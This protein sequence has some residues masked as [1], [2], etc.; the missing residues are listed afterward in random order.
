MN[1][2]EWESIQP[3]YFEV[4]NLQDVQD[5]IVI[6]PPTYPSWYTVP[7]TNSKVPALLPFSSEMLLRNALDE[8]YTLDRF[9]KSHIP[10]IVI[11]NCLCCHVELS[12]NLEH[13][14]TP[15]G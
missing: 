5:G 15:L 14:F 11:F 8:G 1:D 9:V 10:T 4:H 3:N 13:Y 6:D 7:S 12:F 2:S